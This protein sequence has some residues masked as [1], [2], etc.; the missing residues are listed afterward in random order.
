MK[1]AMI[2]IMALAVV[3]AMAWPQTAKVTAP[4]GDEQWIFNSSRD[5]TWT[6]TGNIKIKLLLFHKG[7]EQ[8]GVIK[9]GWKLSLGTFHW[10]VGALEGSAK[11]GV[12]TD[13]CVKIA[14]MDGTVLDE[15]NKPFSI[16]KLDSELTSKTD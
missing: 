11:V 10:T 6:H 9:S 1:K 3:T 4:N 7:G 5:I 8:I 12:G 15:S 13:Y 14:K 2:G 16:I